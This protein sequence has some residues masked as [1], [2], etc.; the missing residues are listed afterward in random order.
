M[1]RYKEKGRYDAFGEEL[2]GLDLALIAVNRSDRPMTPP[3]GF[4]DLPLLGPLGG[5]V[6]L[7]GQVRISL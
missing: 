3:Q 4:E 5:C 2:P 6:V 7:D 1:R